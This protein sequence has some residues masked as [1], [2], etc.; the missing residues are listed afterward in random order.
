MQKKTDK[1]KKK[2][3]FNFAFANIKILCQFPLPVEFSI[4]AWQ[5]YLRDFVNTL[6]NMKETCK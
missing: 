5:Q 4:K 1:L 2:T 6:H 3:L